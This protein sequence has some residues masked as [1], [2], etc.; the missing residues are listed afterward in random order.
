MGGFEGAGTVLKLCPTEELASKEGLKAKHDE[1]V[2]AGF[3]GIM[4]RNKKGLYACKK[5]SSDLQKYKEMMDDEYKIV[6]FYEGEG[7]EAGCVV[8]ECVT[9]EGR[10]FRCR[11]KGTHEERRVLFKD[12]ASALGKM[13]TVTYQ[14]LTTDGIPRF[15]I[16]TVIRDYE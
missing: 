15:P 9:P 6:G 16:G 10:T 12:G 11:P 14:E 2:A 7:E 3:E 5:R 1:Y 8:W 13:L 4:L